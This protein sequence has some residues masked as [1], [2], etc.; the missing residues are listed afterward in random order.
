M[1][2][3]PTPAD[4]LS[5]PDVIDGIRRA[6]EESDVGGDAPTEQGGFILWN[7]VDRTFEVARVPARGRDSLAYPVCGDGNYNGKQIVGSFHTHPNTGSEWRQGPSPQDIRLSQDYPE[8]M[9]PNQFVIASETIYHIDND[10]AVSEMGP[11]A[12]LLRFGR[13]T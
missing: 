2:D 6:Y 3:P 8:T 11:T 4:L 1:N 13:G 5:D 9:G 10:G 7:L 12:E